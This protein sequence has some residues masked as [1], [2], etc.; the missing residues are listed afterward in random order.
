VAYV[1]LTLVVLGV[2]AALALRRRKS[3]LSDAILGF[4]RSMDKTSW[5]AASGRPS[6]VR[7]AGL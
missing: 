2:I 4:A 5:Y 6:R 1:A 7:S 3:L